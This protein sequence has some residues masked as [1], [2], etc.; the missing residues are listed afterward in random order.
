MVST[1]IPTPLKNDGV[2]VSWDDDI[3][4]IWVCLK[5]GYTPNEI[6][7][8]SR[9][10]DQQNHWENGVHDIFRQTHM[11]SHKKFHGS[12]HHQPDSMSPIL[13]LGCRTAV[14]TGSDRLTEMFGIGKSLTQN[15]TTTSQNG[16]LRSP[17]WNI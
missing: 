6:A 5:M 16:S 3:P 13:K 9:D 1:C 7:I 10:N 17:G 11:E 4:N 12:S 8:K 14:R 2:K 15:P